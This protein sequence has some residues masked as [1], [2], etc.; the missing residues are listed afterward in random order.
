ML[1][2]GRVTVFVVPGSKNHFAALNLMGFMEEN[3]PGVDFGGVFFGVSNPA[4][5]P[6][7][8]R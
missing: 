8:L 5:T 7:D 4:T 1:V 6:D 3:L 2:S